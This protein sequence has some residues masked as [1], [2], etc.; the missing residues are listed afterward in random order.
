MQKC[1]WETDTWRERGGK[2]T[3][4]STPAFDLLLQQKSRGQET[5]ERTLVKTMSIA[6]VAA[7]S[8]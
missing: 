8:C 2:N 1:G 4:R 5:R 7:P 6:C 3:P